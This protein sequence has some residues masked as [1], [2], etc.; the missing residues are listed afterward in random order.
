M[1]KN[2]SIE[3]K[4]ENEKKTVSFMIQ[5]YCKKKHGQKKALKSPDFMCE[6]C[7]SLLEYVNQRI[8]H[9]PFMATKTFCSNCPVHCYKKDR[10]EQIKKVMRFSGSMM[11]FYHPVKAIRHVASTIKEKKTLKK[12]AKNS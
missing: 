10:R 2:L 6:E 8:D 11:L 9:C 12:N 1:K 5:L 4:R 3:E 7:K